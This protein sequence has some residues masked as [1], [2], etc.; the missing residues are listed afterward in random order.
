MMRTL[1]LL[2]LLLFCFHGSSTVKHS[3]KFVLTGSTG[4]QNVP[5][6]MAAVL[7]DDVLVG[8]CD[9]NRKI[10]EP[11]QDWVKKLFEDEPEHLEMFTRQCVEETSI[12]FKN[13]M[14]NL[15]RQYN[16]SEGVHILQRI[17]GCEWNNETG[18]VIGFNQYGYDG[19]DF[20]SFDLK[21]ETWNASKPQAVL[22]KL[23]WDADKDKM[24]FNQYI[25]TVIFPE[26]LKKY[27]DY[28]RSFLLRTELPLVSLLQKTPS[29]P[30][31]CLATGFYPHRA[32]LVWR[33]DGEELHEEV[34]HG[35]ILPNH[36]GTFQMSVD[37]NLS[38]VTPEDW[39]RYDCVFQLFGVKEEIITKVE[40]DRIRTN[41]EEPGEVTVLIIVILVLIAVVLITAIGFIVYRKTR[42]E[43]GSEE[44]KK[45]MEEEG[46]RTSTEPHTAAVNRLNPE[47]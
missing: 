28:G 14:G 13:T 27:V 22:T 42:G 23:I 6:F 39:T 4:L 5:E 29:S 16:Q 8:Y 32:S 1:F 35:E 24:K 11:K 34:D 47:T 10:V 19:E 44:E 37:L 20:L 46:A 3:L 30:V 2:L 41:W 43:H 31:S 26:W 17:S 9:T 38:S 45:R 36:D 40:E 21:T 12:F 7:V 18:E 33:K 15:K 25:L